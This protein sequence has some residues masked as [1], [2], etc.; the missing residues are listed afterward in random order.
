MDR[1]NP[2][3]SG[4]PQATLPDR[5]LALILFGEIHPC[6]FAPPA[7]TM[8]WQTWRTRLGSSVARPR[9]WRQALI[10][11]NALLTRRALC[12]ARRQTT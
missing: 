5:S 4:A 8:S 9:A 11:S 7:S 10:I 1:D 2:S 3:Q 12:S 6:L